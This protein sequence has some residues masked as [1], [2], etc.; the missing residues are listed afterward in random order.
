MKI[1]AFSTY[2]DSGRLS[3][4]LK[5]LK[6]IK[7][8]DLFLLV[9]D[10]GSEDGTRKFLRDW[11]K[12]NKFSLEIAVYPVIGGLGEMY[13][14]LFEN[15]LKYPSAKSCVILDIDAEYIS[16][17]AIKKLLDFT[18]KEDY[19]FISPIYQSHHFDGIIDKIFS[20]PLIS[21]LFGKTIY[22]IGGKDFAISK[23]LIKRLLSKRFWE[24]PQYRHNETYF[25]ITALAEEYYKAC[26]F[27]LGNKNLDPKDFRAF[28]PI[29]LK[30]AVSF[31]EGMGEYQSLWKKS[32]KQ[33]KINSFNLPKKTF[34]LFSFSSLPPEIFITQFKKSFPHHQ[35]VFRNILPV[36]HFLFLK[37]LAK[38][39]K[40][41]FYLSSNLWAEIAYDFAIEF[42]KGSFSQKQLLDALLCIFW[43]EVASFYLSLTKNKVELKEIKENFIKKKKYL[44]K[45]WPVSK[46]FLDEWFFKNKFHHKKFSNINELVRLKR[47][48]RLTIGLC[49]LAKNEAD[50]IRSTIEI[51]KKPLFD[52]SHLLDEIIVLDGG[53]RD[54]TV[55]EAKK[56]GV[57]VYT[58]SSVLP[59][60]PPVAGD[61]KKGEDLWK[62]IYLLNTDILVWV[63][64]DIL[65]ISPQFVYGTIGP[66]L[67]YPRLGHCIGF[68]Q[69]PMKIGKTIV[70]EEGGRVT[71]LTVRPILNTFFPDLSRIIQPLSGEYATRRELIEKIPIFTNYALE[72]CMLIDIY[73]AFGLDVIAQVDLGEKIH[74][75]KPLTVLAKRSFGIIQAIFNR[76][77]LHGKIKLLL[78]PIVKRGRYNF[79]EITIT[80][81]QKPPIIELPEYQKKFNDRKIKWP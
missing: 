10:G 13:K 40:K 11:A 29:F 78:E 69:R 24:Y 52:K 68:Y 72:T 39:E 15:V 42:C 38:K 21:A 50:S 66:L 3:S 60:I 44:L 14:T 80:E 48:Q 41:D 17:S 33:T 1:I 73:S 65:N 64:A 2:N 5:K 53:S 28:G 55:K 54:A 37:E 74:K 16:S 34:L 26:L 43:A 22:P 27:Y 18:E 56:A 63:D 58:T 76:L 49:V 46:S 81:A 32:K 30:K 61:W 9:V 45:Y 67:K 19:D 57:K 62:S 51:I 31:F 75:N 71:E 6:T 47:K 77:N 70:S 7:S 23:K 79:E 35:N 12:E 25:L 8:K 4:F 36:R 59:H 20:T